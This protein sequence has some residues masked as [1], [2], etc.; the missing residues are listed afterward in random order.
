VLLNIAT[1]AVAYSPPGS[2]VRI[3]VARQREEAV[4]AVRDDGCGI[5][6]DDLPHIFEPFYRA[7][8]AR[9]RETGGTGL[10]LAIADQIVRAHGGLIH[11]SS[12]LGRGS[13]FTIALPVGR[14]A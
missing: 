5:G 3:Q 13:V 14:R 9:A 6:P 12:E 1:N 7:D 11:V 10:G 4:V 8:P 2:T